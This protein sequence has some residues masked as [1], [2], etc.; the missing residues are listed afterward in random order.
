[1]PNP[2]CLPQYSRPTGPKPLLFRCLDLCLLLVP[3]TAS[4]AFPR[5][6]ERLFPRPGITSNPRLVVCFRPSVFVGPDV[7]L[8]FTGWH[9]VKVDPHQQVNVFVLNDVMKT[10]LDDFL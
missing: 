4:L 7:N 8:L 5:H 3:L 10:T 6:K 9:F 2:P 1:M